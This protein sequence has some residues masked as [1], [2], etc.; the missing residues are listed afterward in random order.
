MADLSV[1]GSF[2]AGVGIRYF[3]GITD[4]AFYEENGQV[5][6]FVASE[7]TNDLQMYYVYSD[8]V[9]KYRDTEDFDVATGALSVSE[10]EIV[11]ITGNYFVLT[12]GRYDDAAELAPIG[13]SI[14]RITSPSDVTGDASDYANLNKTHVVTVGDYSYVLG[15]KRGDDHLYSYRIEEDG[16]FTSKT[17]VE[18]DPSVTLGDIT[19]FATI[20]I[21]GTFYVAV[22]SAFDGGVTIF[23]LGEHG[24]LHYRDTVLPGDGD[25]FAYPQEVEFI[26]SGG[27]P[28]LVMIASG[29]SSISVY[30]LGKHGNLHQIDFVIDSLDTRFEGGSQLAAISHDGRSFVFVAGNDDGLTVFE[31]L[32]DGTLLHSIT[33]ADN[34]D[35]ALTNVSAISV[36]IID[37]E[38]HVFVAGAED[39]MTQF[40]FDP[41]DLGGTFVGGT[42][43]DVITGTSGNDFLFGG[44][45][46]DKIDG[47]AGDDRIDGGGGKDYLTGGAGA[48]TFV[49]IADGRNDFIM[50]FQ[51]GLD[52]IDLSGY[53]QIG[54]LNDLVIKTREWGVLIE[55]RGEKLKVIARDG[56]TITAEDFTVDDF[57]F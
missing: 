13:G 35:I 21:D 23:K 18:D 9:I 26:V 10:I 34:F 57:I 46:G 38:I 55:I 14:P 32:P 50:D 56:D 43:K 28:Y 5:Y 20:E 4:F 31:L 53:H 17:P 42:G 41:D 16:Q 24:N 44:R 54:T 29:S 22:S 19:S 2:Y 49:F 30:E 48:D 8:E 15:S 52:L 47:G 12:S 40:I 3:S 11:E 7:G 25:G 33:L 37:G 45:R 1:V 36:K 27:N 6:L 51:D 39:G